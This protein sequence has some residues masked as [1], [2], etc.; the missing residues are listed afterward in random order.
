MSKRLQQGL[1]KRERQMVEVIYRVREADAAQVQ[2]E[3]PE[4]PG[5][6]SVRTTLNILV[7][8][9][10][11]SVR[12]VGRKYLYAPVIPRE[13]ARLS[14]LKQT[15][16]TY[17]DNSIHAAVS[18]LLRSNRGGLTDDEYQSLVRLIDEARKKG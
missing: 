4:P 9:G 6:S 13:R 17:F 7:E 12:R 3:I 5:Y 2:A 18:T 14:A 16:Q 8:K 10:L 11:L 1:S 15:V